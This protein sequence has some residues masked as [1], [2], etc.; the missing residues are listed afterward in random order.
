MLAPLDKVER[1]LPRWPPCQAPQPELSNAPAPHST[2]PFGSQVPGERLD[3]GTQ[4]AQG[5]GVSV[6]GWRP[7]LA[8]SPAGAAQPP[9][10]RGAP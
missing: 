7:L 3:L 4:V 10:S 8:L 1:Q 5:P 2:P 9:D 6:N